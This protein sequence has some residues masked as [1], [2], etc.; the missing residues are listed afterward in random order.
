MITQTE[1]EKPASQESRAAKGQAE[2]VVGFAI[3]GCLMAG[4]VGIWKASEMASGLDVL[5]CLLGSVTAFGTVF[6][7]FLD[8]R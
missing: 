5:L 7:I 2:M 1:T 3:L 6:Y 8:R 4:G